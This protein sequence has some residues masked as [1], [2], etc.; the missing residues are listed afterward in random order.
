[1]G[2]PSARHRR[3][4]RRAHGAAGQPLGRGRA[5]PVGLGIDRDRLTARALP[6]RG[7]GRHP[8]LDRLPR[9]RRRLRPVAARQLGRRVQQ[10]RHRRRRAC[11]P[12]CAP[13]RSSARY[14][15]RAASRRVLPRPHGLRRPRSL[16]RAQ[17]APPSPRLWRGHAPDR[18]RRRSQRGGPPD[19]APEPGRVYAGYEV[20][21][22][23]VPGGRARSLDDDPDLP[24]VL[25]EPDQL[26]A[27]LDSHRHRRHR[28]DAATTC[29]RPSRCARWP[30][31]CTAPA[32]SC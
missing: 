1:M 13:R 6:R 9:H 7:P 29:S 10:G 17:V 30:G 22:A 20:V 2:T 8:D 31:A 12:P 26:V 27:D 28:R 25:G 32:S 11:S 5:G 21:G 16:P 3:R 19:H 14:R 4:C 18:R 15:S 24:I 23:Y